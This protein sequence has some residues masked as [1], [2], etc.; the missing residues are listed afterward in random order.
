M[1]IKIYPLIYPPMVSNMTLVVW[2]R[3]SCLPILVLMIMILYLATSIGVMKNIMIGA[4]PKHTP[5]SKYPFP[6][7]KGQVSVER[8]Y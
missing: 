2:I 3:I 1:Q 8:E 6:S 7:Q 5:D 4:R